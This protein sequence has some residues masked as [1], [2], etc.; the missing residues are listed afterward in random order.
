MTDGLL[1]SCLVS[2][3]SIH[4]A[5][6]GKCRALREALG[7]GRWAVPLIH[8]FW[9]QRTLAVMGQQLT[10]TLVARRSRFF[11]G[12]RFQKRGVNHEARFLV[13]SSV[14]TAS[15]CK[16]EYVAGPFVDGRSFDCCRFGKGARLFNVAAEGDGRLQGHLLVSTILQS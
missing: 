13:L 1:Y 12:T 11:A 14:G 8:G 2:G 3:S 16:N 15:C 4:E 10:V 6:G 9:Q 5:L 7:T